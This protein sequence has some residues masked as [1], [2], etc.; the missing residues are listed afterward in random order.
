MKAAKK[1]I[2]YFFLII[3]LFGCR[4]EKEDVLPPDINITAPVENQ[5]VSIPDTISV[6]A[7]ITDDSPLTEVHVDIV[8]ANL[9]P[10]LPSVI[11]HPM[12]TSF[13]VNIDYPVDDVMLTSGYYYVHVFASDGKNT[14]NDYK[15][16]HVNAIPIRFLFVAAVT[17]VNYNTLQVIKIDTGFTTSPMFTLN[18]D[19]IASDVNGKNQ[20][21]YIAG[22]YFGNVNAYDLN[23]NTLAWSI[24]ALINPP[25]PCFTGLYYNGA[26]A[27]VS[28]YNGTVKGY[29]KDGALKYSINT[30]AGAYPGKL[31]PHNQYLFTE[32]T[33]VSGG[34][35]S[36]AVYY[37]STSYLMQQLPV[38]Y[39]VVDFYTKDDDDVFAF[40]NVAGQGMMKIYS[41]T[42]NNVWQPI[43]IPVGKIYSVAQI[44]ADHYLIAHDN[45]IYSYDYSTNSL[46]LFI[47]G[48]QADK[49]K[50]N[51][52]TNEVYASHAKTINV[53]N[54]PS[55]TPVNSV[56][57]SD[58]IRDF[59]LVFNK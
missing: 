48:I 46:V 5:Q 52:L 11:Y 39:S 58:T 15:K 50:Y 53:Y 6:K 30:P 16:I 57:L 9:I 25:F 34:N 27:L 4:K 51:S 31:F 24:P 1:L 19:Y 21:L 3:L 49:I 36:I 43:T 23:T 44:D 26:Y 45:G 37:Y 7:G 20:L 10:V 41:I 8:D 22:N 55:A 28:N 59:H 42:D 32:L 33:L 35:K 38:T 12:Q 17:K 14:K 2:L 13:Q 47:P 54:Y 29:D 40:V 56:V 18:S